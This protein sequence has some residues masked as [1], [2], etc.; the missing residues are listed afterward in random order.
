MRAQV[1]NYAALALSTA[2]LIFISFPDAASALPKHDKNP[3]DSL[4]NKGPTSCYQDENCYSK[5][6]WSRLARPLDAVERVLT[7][8]E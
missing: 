5:C 3:G 8:G 2:T 6:P 7:A 1:S 4:R